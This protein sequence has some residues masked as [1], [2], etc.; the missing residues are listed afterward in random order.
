MDLT[1]LMFGL[2]FFGVGILFILG[3]L[4][5]HMS[6]WRTM[7]RAE[8]ARIRVEALRCNIGCMIAL[9]GIVF[10]LAGLSPVFKERFFTWAMIAWLIGSGADI[11]YIEK[12]GKYYR[13]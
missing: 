2:M 6:V 8:R 12:K 5:V 13:S 7:T 11:W 4:H 10:L 1:C 9:C 3:K